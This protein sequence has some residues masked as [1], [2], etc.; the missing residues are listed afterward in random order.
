MEPPN[1][2]WF[3]NARRAPASRSPVASR[4]LPQPP[5]PR[6]LHP[7]RSFMHKRQ[8][9]RYPFNML[10]CA[11]MSFMFTADTVSRSRTHTPTHSTDFWRETPNSCFRPRCFNRGWVSGIRVIRNA[12]S[13]S[14]FTSDVSFSP[15]ARRILSICLLLVIASFW[16]FELMQP[17]VQQFLNTLCTIELAAAILR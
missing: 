13:S 5:F 10:S 6:A 1:A 11:V 9:D 4:S 2:S 12:P 7:K 16:F 17:M 14:N 15:S 8:S 3:R